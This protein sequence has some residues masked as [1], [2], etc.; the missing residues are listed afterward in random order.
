MRKF[1][2]C[3]AVIMTLMMIGGRASAVPFGDGGVALQAVL[4]NITIGPNPGNSSTNVLTDAL[5]DDRDSYWAI[6]GSGGSV[7]TVIIELATWSEFN[8]FGIYDL[9][10]PSKMVQIFDGVATNGSQAVLNILADGSVRVNFVDTGIDFAGNAFGYYLDSRAGH[11]GWTGGIW[12]SDTSL[13]ADGQDHMAAYQ[14]KGIDTVQIFPFAPGIWDQDEHILAFED[15]HAMHWGNQNGVNDGY[16]EWS[17]VEPDFTDFVV[18]VES[19][20][21]VPEPAT[22]L[23]LGLGL[24]GV[25]G[26]NRK[27][28]M[29]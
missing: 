29:G 27:K 11:P 25:A 4:D 8:L 22:L 1:I 15:L 17:D 7:S 20:G 24:I 13:N 12:Y 28:F 18:M 19:V 6:H 14:G 5:P 23:L 9:S 21:P 16:P 26:L 3:L 2:I 10:N